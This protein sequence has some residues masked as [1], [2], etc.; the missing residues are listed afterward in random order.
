MIDCASS[1]YANLDVRVQ[2]RQ[3]GRYLQLVAAVTKFQE[4][5]AYSIL[6]LAYG[7]GLKAQL[8][9]AN[10]A[11]NDAIATLDE[12][13]GRFGDATEPEL[14]QVSARALAAR[15]NCCC[16]RSI[17]GRRSSSAGR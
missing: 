9:A 12:L 2:Q 3:V 14:R 17:R 7:L 5:H 8:F 13:L 15:Q 11:S 4:R 16:A 1:Q 10:A 6:S